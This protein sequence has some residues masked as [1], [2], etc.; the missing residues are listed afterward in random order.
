MIEPTELIDCQPASPFC[1]PDWRWRRAEGIR[2]GLLRDTPRRRDRWV[3]RALKFLID[4][5]AGRGDSSG[6]SSARPD[7]AILGA[8][9]VRSSGDPR[10]RMELEARVLAGQA[11]GE[12]AARLG[13]THDVVEAYQRLH[14]DVRD[15]LGSTGYIVG[16]VIAH[17][18]HEGFAA[19]DIESILKVFA[20]G[21]G[22][23]VLDTLIEVLG[24]GDAV[25]VSPAVT[26]NP[27]LTRAVRCAIAARSIPVT[28][29]TAPILVR[30]NVLFLEVGRRAA[31][32]V[33]LNTPTRATVEPWPAPATGRGDRPTVPA[34]SPLSVEAAAG[35]D[36]VRG[37]PEGDSGTAAVCS[38]A[39]HARPETSMRRT[40]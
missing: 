32:D 10:T 3:G 17:T 19:G 14:F 27:D 22:P 7:P 12:I 16:T 4:R 1:P 8:Y 25:G 11:P 9:R 33:A 2:L 23:V 37:G 18:L 24:V 38:E 29:R 30:L 34:V 15:R 31:A 5:A 20:Y 36:R 39:D 28:E 26:S 35:H 40:A 6:P 13:L 21:Y